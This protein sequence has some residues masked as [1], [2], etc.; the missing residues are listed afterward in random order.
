MTTR[1]NF[2][3]KRVAILN[4]IQ[5]TKVHPTAEWVYQELKPEYPDLSLG[6][7]YRNIKSFSED[8]LVQSV[9]VIGGQEHFDGNV[10]PHSHFICDKCNSIIDIEKSFFTNADKNQIGNELGFTITSEDVMFR[11]VCS[12][13]LKK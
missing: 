8:G 12:T 9:G 11:G 3:R 10:N 5:S 1:Q 4:K 6:T 2:S 13:C 7:V